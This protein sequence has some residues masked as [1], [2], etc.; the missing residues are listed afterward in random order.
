MEAYRRLAVA[1]KPDD[2]AA[3]ERDVVAAYGAP[4][5]SVRRLIDVTELRVALTGLGI[6][7][8]AVKEK[9]VVFFATDPVGLM[10][11]LG[12]RRARCG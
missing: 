7:T 6:R 8:M 1:G 9:D 5:P 10:E 4:P 2:V 12:R 3:F 11:R